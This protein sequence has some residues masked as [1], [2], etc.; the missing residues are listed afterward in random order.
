MSGLALILVILTAIVILQI[1]LSLRSNKYL[2]LIFPFINLLSSIYISLLFSDMI[3][4][5][6]GFVVSLIP[7]IIW[8]SIYHKCKKKMDKK[9]QNEINRMTINDL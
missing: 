1:F 3:V 4:A 8:I 6:L 7:M 5:I 2:G 9:I